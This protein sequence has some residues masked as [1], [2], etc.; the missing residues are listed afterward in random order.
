MKSW[1]FGITA[2]IIT[3][4]FCVVSYWQYQEKEKY[5]I[6]FIES[7]SENLINEQKVNYSL[8]DLQSARESGKQDGKVEAMLMIYSNTEKNI[9]DESIEKIISIAENYPKNL[10]NNMSFLSLLSQAAFHKGLASGKESSESNYEQGYHKAIEDF[11]CPET[12]KMVV[13]QKD[14]KP[15]K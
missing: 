7:I 8:A 11:S 2:G 15:S 1:L 6:L 12:G 14:A 4:L 5:K 9:D 10:E 13:P 3:F